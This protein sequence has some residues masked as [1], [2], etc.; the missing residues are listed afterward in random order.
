MKAKATV[1]QIPH[2]HEGR[3]NPLPVFRPEVVLTLELSGL[4]TV[5]HFNTSA[6]LA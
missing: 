4:G 3:V 6:S 5:L 2:Q 1:V